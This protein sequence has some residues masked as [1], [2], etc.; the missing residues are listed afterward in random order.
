MTSMPGR[1][2]TA[3]RPSIA[4]LCGVEA[5]SARQ[6][7]VGAISLCADHFAQ[8]AQWDEWSRTNLRSL[9]T[10]SARARV[11]D[12]DDQ[13]AD[14][15]SARST[16]VAQ[17]GAGAAA[18]AAEARRLHARLHHDPEEAELGAAQGRQGAP[19]QWL[20]SHRLHPGRRP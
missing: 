20:R 17:E 6:R 13:P 9:P 4:V 7:A 1:A 14:R 16:E 11:N 15:K 18:V 19:D 10:V 5:L 3:D 2:A 12:A 8:G